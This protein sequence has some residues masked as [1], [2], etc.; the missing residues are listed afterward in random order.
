MGR[1]DLSDLASSQFINPNIA[2]DGRR[3]VT[4]KGKEIDLNDLSNQIVKIS[5]S[6]KK[7]DELSYEERSNAIRVV[8]MIKTAYS[9][10]DKKIQKKNVFTQALV[11][12]RDF[13]GSFLT[14][15]R[16]Q[17]DKDTASHHFT[18]YSPK[19]SRGRFFM[20]KNTLHSLASQCPSSTLV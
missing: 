15:A 10:T 7:V 14:N 20:P 12:M 18:G 13:F 9:E 4:V 11:W 17:I 2:L 3:I 5:S 1:L 8:E 6:S 19:T 16:S